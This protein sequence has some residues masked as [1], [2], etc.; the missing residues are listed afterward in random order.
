MKILIVSK[1]YPTLK[2][3]LYGIFAFDQAKALVKAGHDVIFA[4]V[5]MRSIRK[6][7]KWGYESL[8]SEN[9]NIECINIPCGS[10]NKN[11]WEKTTETAMRMLWQRIEKKFGRPDV[12]HS[13]FIQEGYIASK[14]FEC[15]GIPMVITEHYSGMNKGN[16]DSYL[17]K[18]GEYTYSRMDK[19]LAVSNTLADNI[20][21]SFGVE[22]VTIPNIVD[23]EKFNYTEREIKERGFNFISV[24]NL[25]PLKNMDGMIRA[26]VKAFKTT[27]GVHLYIAGDGPERRKIEGLINDSGMND[28][29]F[30]TGY[31]DR[32]AIAALMNGCDCFVLASR[33]ETF[34]VALIEAMAAGLPVISTRSG[35]PEDFIDEQNGILVPVDDQEK[36]REAMIFMY[37]N[38]ERYSGE[39]ISKEITRKYSPQSVTGSLLKIYEEV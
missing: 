24:G 13:H 38:I 35:G 3:G 16:I 31:M 33:S 21:R 12:I 7:R 10:L 14:V 27:E 37:E 36:F 32:S 34:G 23:L 11:L 25:V 9:V 18:L 15:E 5:D 26:F 2:Y 28:R 39:K 8:R 19:V 30:L 29:I 22:V 1:G 4:A 20:R 17:H 6:W